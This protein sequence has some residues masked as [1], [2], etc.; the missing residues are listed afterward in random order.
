MSFLPGW[1]LIDWSVK[2]IGRS[3]LLELLKIGVV[4]EHLLTS[5]SYV[6]L[7]INLDYLTTV[8]LRF[9]SVNVI[10][11]TF[12]TI[13]HIQH[14]IFRPFTVPSHFWTLHASIWAF[15]T[16]LWSS[17]A[18]IDNFIIYIY[19]L[20]NTDRKGFNESFFTFITR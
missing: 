13:D 8:F 19:Y 11:Q 16:V 17:F 3:K 1:L 5:V 7:C 14:E 15:S 6:I 10:L 12:R 4:F 20:S 18:C 2:N 9:W